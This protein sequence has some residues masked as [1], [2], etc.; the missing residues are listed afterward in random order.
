MFYKAFIHLSLV[1][2]LFWATSAQNITAC[3]NNTVRYNRLYLID[4]Y[5]NYTIRNC[6]YTPRLVLGNCT[7]T[8]EAV[9]T[10]MKGYLCFS[11]HSDVCLPTNQS[12]VI[13]G[14]TTNC[15]GRIFFTTRTSG[16]YTYGEEFH[17]S[18]GPFN[19]TGVVVSQCGATGSVPPPP[20]N[21]TSPRR[22]LFRKK[23]RREL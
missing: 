8:G 21:C 10:P 20:R 9:I 1:A 7:V 16:N 22:V 13:A 3:P 6:S 23:L 12:R 15:T 18:T 11:N 19:L 2:L 4:G 17:I 5:V 14:Y